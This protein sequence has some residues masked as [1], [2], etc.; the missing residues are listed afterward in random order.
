MSTKFLRSSTYI[1][2]VTLLFSCVVFVGMYAEENKAGCNQSSDCYSCSNELDLNKLCAKSIRTRCLDAKKIESCS[3]HT[4]DLCVDNQFTALSLIASSIDTESI[5]TENLMA[6]VGCIGQLTANNACIPGSL[7]AADFTQCSKYAATV[8]FGSDTVYTLGSNVAFDTIL[9]D[10]NNNVFI[11]P[12]YMQ[13]TAPKTGYYIVTVQI[14]QHGLNG[15]NTL[16]G[17]PVTNIEL[18]VNGIITRQTFVPYLSFHDAQKG[19]YSALLGLKQGDILTTGYNVFVMNDSAGFIPYVGTLT[20][21]GN[22]GA[23]NS[24]LFKIH[25]LS[26]TCSTA[27]CV[28]CVVGCTPSVTGCTPTDCCTQ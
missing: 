7:V 4:E 18:F 24:S 1:F 27:P 26:V 14:D 8:V 9:D 20:I 21:E 16:V 25:L 13:Y 10:A 12:G 3:I 6:T 19:N 15:A 22:A 28:P 23:E 2:A 11:A 5:C 17:M